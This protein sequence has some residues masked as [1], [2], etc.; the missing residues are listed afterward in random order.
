MNTCTY[1]CRRERTVFVYERKK[2]TA[3]PSK[4][5]MDAVDAAENLPSFVAFPKGHHFS[6]PNHQSRRTILV[7]AGGSGDTDV[8]L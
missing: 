1:V 5:N 6:V 2:N 8:K 4:S 3:C 7:G